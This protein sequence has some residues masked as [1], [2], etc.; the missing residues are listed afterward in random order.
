MSRPKVGA[1]SH[2]RFARSSARNY[3]KQM[4]RRE[5]FEPPTLRFEERFK[6]R[7]TPKNQ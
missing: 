6:R 7:K 3:L 1:R 2:E 5:G 4:A